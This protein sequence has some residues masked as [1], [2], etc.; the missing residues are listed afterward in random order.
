MNATADRLEFAPPAQ[1]GFTRAFILAVIA[2]LL[3]LAALTWGVSWRR[4]SN[5]LSAEAEL[6]SAV[7]Q[8]AAPKPVETPPPPPAPVAAPAPAPPPVQR[9]ADIAI[10]REKQR[11]QAEARR[12]EEQLA[13][14]KR[15]QA[16]QERDRQEAQKK[17]DLAKKAAEDKKKLDAAAKARDA[18]EAQADARRLE[19]Q[20]EQN[21]Q[22]L[23][24]LAGATGG[25]TATGT[26]QRASGPSDSYGGR[27]RAR[28]KPNIVF[29]DDV[30][31]NP[32]AEVEVR[33]APDGTIVATKIIKSSGVRSWDDAVVKALTKTE[34]LPRDIDGR[35]PSPIVISFR[36]KD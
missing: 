27:I 1:P 21:L 19:A 12:R 3:L 10:E 22:R 15:L 23:A 2:H 33:A 13:Q 9:D 32:V 5:E 18:K 34:V 17:L 24:G 30:P 29:T 11:Q 16:R 8:Q 26:A 25:P 6:W 7:P 28:V 35:V 14:Q 20:R 36:P 31:G 4:D